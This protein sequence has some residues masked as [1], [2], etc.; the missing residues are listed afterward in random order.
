MASWFVLPWLAVLT[1]C[2][3]GDSLVDGMFSAVEIEQVK[4][5]GP[6]PALPASPT[7]LYADNP[8]AAAFGQRLFHETSYTGALTV[9]DDGTNG[10]VGM[11]GDTGKLGCLKCHVPT[12]WWTDSRSNP[13]ATSLGNQ[14]TS[15]NAPSLVNI[16]FYKWHGWAGKRDTLW[17]QEATSPESAQDGA[18]TRLQC[19]HMLYA[20]YRADYDA[21]FPV[22]LDPA[23]DP[24][25]ADAARFPPT[26][27]PKANA[28]DPDGPWELM[29]DADRQIVLRIMANWGK[30]V[31]AYDRLLVSRNAP[32][33][34]YVAGDLTALPAAAKRG[35][36]LFIGKA[37][38]VACH[39]GPTFT[40][41]LF[42]NTGVPQVG[43]HVPM[44]DSGRFTDVATLLAS[45]YRGDG[46]LS[47]D[48]VAGAEM[49]AGV[50]Q[51]PADKGKFRTKALR[52]V[53]ET[54]P[55]MHNGSLKTLEEVVHFYNLG[56]GSTGFD[57]TKDPKMVPLNLTPAEEAD[58]VAFQKQLTGDPAPAA[59]AVNTAAP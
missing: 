4:K 10:A 38:C 25:A 31:E 37:A 52:D 59:L 54:G 24:A 18:G 35:L 48:P 14:W 30:S 19:A 29:A 56:G 42:H 51:D 45:P 57:G 33:D 27:K 40:D 8:A 6:L 16:A 22:K 5:L 34:R 1:G 50:T 53:A 7:N 20:K 49:L 15:R 11:V 47:D 44:M 41:D 17:H 13:N 58:L 3:G 21:I 28:T 55:Y 2:G 26:G 39:S 43:D 46:A 36:K 23:L 9:G 32:I 12:T